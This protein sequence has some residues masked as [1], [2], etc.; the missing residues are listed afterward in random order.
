MKRKYLILYTA[1]WLLTEYG[2]KVNLRNI[3]F[4]WPKA[5]TMVD[6]DMK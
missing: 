6:E 2:E 3:A 5:R 4:V 1:V